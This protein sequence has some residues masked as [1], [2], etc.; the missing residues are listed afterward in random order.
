MIPSDATLLEAANIICR[1]L[2]AGWRIAIELE[3]NSG[4]VT[5][6]DPYGDDVEYPSNHETFLDS[7]NDAVDYAMNGGTDGP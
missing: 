2:P 6:T 1:D 3:F 4:C 7:L 5:L